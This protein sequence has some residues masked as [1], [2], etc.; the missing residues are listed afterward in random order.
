MSGSGDM[1]SRL[2]LAVP[3]GKWASLA[4]IMLT[5]RLF[6]TVYP[7]FCYLAAGKI[8]WALS[9]ISMAIM[10]KRIKS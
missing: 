6:Y 8:A 7:E 3:G 2:I 4:M 9:L 10:K 1:V 5:V